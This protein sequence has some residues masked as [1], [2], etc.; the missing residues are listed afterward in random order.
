MS[1]HQDIVTLV[2]KYYKRNYIDTKA[3][4]LSDEWKGI[5]QDFSQIDWHHFPVQLDNLRVTDL[6][7]TEMTHS[8]RNLYEHRFVKVECCFDHSFTVKGKEDT[9]K[10]TTLTLPAE[11]K[12]QLPTDMRID[13]MTFP[14]S[15]NYTFFN[16]K[17]ENGKGKIKTLKT[18]YTADA[19]VQTTFRG[20]AR[21]TKKNGETD[22]V[23][24]SEAI[25]YFSNQK[26]QFRENGDFVSLGRCTI[27]IQKKT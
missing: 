5:A 7:E 15:A 2:K 25:K 6:N 16:R 13:Q 3:G 1:N 23:E 11:I 18:T 27:T 20:T 22:D 21:F 12:D 17:T 24:I 8:K 14:L 26:D 4:S 19:S 9:T 10:E